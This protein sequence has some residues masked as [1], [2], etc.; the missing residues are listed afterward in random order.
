M[1]YRA[2]FASAA[3]LPMVALAT[4]SF[5]AITIATGNA[6]SNVH[7]TAPDTNLSDFLT[8]GTIAGF[9]GQVIFTGLEAIAPSSDNGNGNPWVTDVAGN[10]ISYLDIS[11]SGGQFFTGAGFNLNTINGGKPQSWTVSIKAYDA[12]NV[13]HTLT[14]GFGPLKNDEKFVVNTTDGWKLTNVQITTSANIGGVGQ[15]SING[16][17]GVTA[18]VPEPAAWALMILGFGGAGAALRRQRRQ[19]ALA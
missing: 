1:T 16:I 17:G 14:S 19:A 18:A 15:V 7:L 6:P 4:P 12:N 2:L 10:G 8:Y 11:L 5:A 13:L 3:A 9:N